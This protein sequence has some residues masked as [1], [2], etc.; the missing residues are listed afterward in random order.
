MTRLAKSFLLLFFFSLCAAAIIVT[1]QLRNHVPPPAPH[2][3]YSVVN[4]Q[5]AAFRA[6]DFSSAYR[7]AASGVQEKFSLSQFENMVRRNYAAVTETHRVEFGTVQ[8]EG[9]SALVQVFF[10][11]QD[12]G[13]QGFLYNLVA[14]EGAWKIEGVAPIPGSRPRQSLSGLHA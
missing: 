6:S 5:L 1:H 12:G 14:E 13:V 11:A 9:A 10:V 2:E 4:S 8:V 7:N 3:L